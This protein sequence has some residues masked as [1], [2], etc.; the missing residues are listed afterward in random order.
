MLVLVLVLELVLELVLVKEESR[1][2]GSRLEDYK[3]EE[4]T[5]HYHMQPPKGRQYL[6]GLNLI[7]GFDA[8]LS[9]INAFMGL[10][11]LDV[12]MKQ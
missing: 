1:Q 4:S 7:L 2:E 5:E 9:L 6:T 3:Q 10:V 11:V 8:S 12:L